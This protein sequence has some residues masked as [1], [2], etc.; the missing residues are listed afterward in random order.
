MRLMMSTISSTKNGARPEARLV[1]QQKLRLGHQRA[2]DREH[3]LLAAGQIAGLRVGA[4]GETRKP[5]EG[6]F[7]RAC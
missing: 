3:L 5:G 6:A 2:A 4:L 7:D 1:Q